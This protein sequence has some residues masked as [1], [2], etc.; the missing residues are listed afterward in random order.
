MCAKYEGITPTPCSSSFTINHEWWISTDICWLPSDRTFKGVTPRVHTRFVQNAPKVGNPIGR[1]GYTGSPDY[2][3][4]SKIIFSL[5]S[6]KIC[7]I[8]TKYEGITP[9]N[10]KVRLIFRFLTN[11]Y[12]FFH[13]LGFS[14]SHLIS[15]SDLSHWTVHA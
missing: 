1:S 9:K 14:C 10:P 4:S 15:N 8:L 2:V 3:F 13:I 5:F 12:C 11:K 7:S 6:L